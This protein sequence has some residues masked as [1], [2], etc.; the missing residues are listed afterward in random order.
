MNKKTWNNYGYPDLH[1]WLLPGH[2]SIILYLKVYCYF[3]YY[4]ANGNQKPTVDPAQLQ[5]I[6]KIAKQCEQRLLSNG[7]ETNGETEKAKSDIPQN[8]NSKEPEKDSRGPLSSGR[9]LENIIGRLNSDK[10]THH[11]ATGSIENSD[12]DDEALICKADAS[13]QTSLNF[14]KVS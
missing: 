2:C 10:V 8:T 1:K 12:D 11:P 6:Q 3:L 9:K 5:R 14:M 4:P 7:N 13:T